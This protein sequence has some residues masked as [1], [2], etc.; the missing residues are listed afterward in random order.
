MEHASQRRVR[1]TLAAW[2]AI[3]TLFGP[4]WDPIQWIH[5]ASLFGALK[6]IESRR[7]YDAKTGR[8]FPVQ[9]E[10]DKLTLQ[11][12]KQQLMIYKSCR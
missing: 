2:V 12:L 6:V 8:P 11:P 7:N 3:F 1:I 9:T 4:E 5:S 10:E